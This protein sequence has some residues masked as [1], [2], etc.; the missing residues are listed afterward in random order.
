M[1]QKLTKTKTSVLMFPT[2]NR[3][4]YLSIRRVDCAYLLS[5]EDDSVFTQHSSELVDEIF[6]KAAPIANREKK[7]EIAII[8]KPTS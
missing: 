3:V 7:T 8:T 4:K 2:G 6:L 5:W 1:I